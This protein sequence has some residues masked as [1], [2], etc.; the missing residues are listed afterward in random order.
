MK[1]DL[2]TVYTFV[3]VVQAGSFKDA[4]D[5]MGISRPS[6]SHHIA[7][8]EKYLKFTLLKRG[9]GG[10]YLTE[11]GED[12]YQYSLDLIT[13]LSDFQTSVDLSDRK[14]EGNLLVTTYYGILNYV[15]PILIPEFDK[16]YPNIRLSMKGD[17]NLLNYLEDKHFKS[18]LPEVQIRTHVP[19]RGDLIQKKILSFSTQIFAH[20]DYIK[21]FGL[22]KRIE[23]LDHHRLL[24]ISPELTKDIA[25]LDWARVLG[26]SK[27]NPR[28]YHMSCNTGVALQKLCA[29]GLGI[30][31]LWPKMDELNNSNLV[32]ILPEIETPIVNYYC[33]YPKKFSNIKRIKTFC[34]FLEK[35]LLK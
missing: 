35:K 28:P 6:V 1:L 34:A 7:N 4:G 29:S 16:L 17:N 30:A 13:K 9:R 20:E 33:V 15:L 18:S 22:P 31:C 21:K 11:K 19:D 24:T 25:M 14:D 27:N 26:R 23:D 2:N 3:Q 5:L 8:L 12:F 32:R 10:V